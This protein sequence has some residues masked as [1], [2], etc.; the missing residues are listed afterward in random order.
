MDGA[1]GVGNVGGNAVIRD[2]TLL[3]AHRPLAPGCRWKGRSDMTGLGLNPDELAR[4]A[5][6]VKELQL[7]TDASGVQAAFDQFSKSLHGTDL[8]RGISDVVRNDMA[9]H[10]AAVLNSPGFKDIAR[11]AAESIKPISGSSS[12]AA[13]FQASAAIRSINASIATLGGAFTEIAVSEPS[14]PLEYVLTDPTEH[15]VAAKSEDPELGLEEE[16]RQ[17]DSQLWAVAWL[18]FFTLSIYAQA[19]GWEYSYLISILIQIESVSGRI[20]TAFP[21]IQP[22]PDESEAGTEDSL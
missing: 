9:E 3:G 13:A 15:T 18:A 11:A 7:A 8:F 21:S 20:H 14:E 6:Q 16:A 17:L 2:N 19:R 1:C 12:L 22:P 5:R 4:I 10:M